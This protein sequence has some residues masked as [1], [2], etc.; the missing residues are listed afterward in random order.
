VFEAVD[1]YCERLGPGPWAEPINAITN[2]AFL[3]IAYFVRQLANHRRPVSIETWGLIFLIVAIGI[4]SGLFHTL[5]TTWVRVIDVMPILLF[6]LL[7]LWVYCRRIMGIRFEYVFGGL[8][9]YVVAAIV[10]MQFPHI[11]NGSLSYAPAIFFLFLLGLYHI[12]KVKVERYI[13]LSATG[14]FFI[15]LI[16]RTID[17]AICSY[18]PL[19]T[20][21]LWHLCN[22]IVLYLL[23]SGLLINLQSEGIYRQPKGQWL[24]NWWTVG[25]L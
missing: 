10:C 24:P 6:Q 21:F 11:L 15:S 20:H 2:G 5:A 3:I 18:F 22:A 4:G 1:L 23:M 17:M 8:V 7:Y 14:L 12:Y 25:F 9:I 13:L 16:F 19:G